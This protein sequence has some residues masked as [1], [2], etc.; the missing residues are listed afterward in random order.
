MHGR[1]SLVEQ[2]RQLSRDA[3]AVFIDAI[4]EAVQLDPNIGYVLVQLLS[5]RT[6]KRAS[7]RLACRPGLWTVDLAEGL[8]AALPGFQELE[9]LPL[10]LHG[11]EEMAG[12][13]ADAF[14]TAVADARLTRLL[15]QP[16]HARALLD[17]WRTTRELP[18][19]RSEAMRH[20][21]SN[22]L[23]E[24]G[25][26][27]PRRVHDDRRMAL[28]AERLAAVTIFCG[29]GRFGLGQVNNPS[30]GSA[31]SALLPVTAVPT[32]HEPDLAG[33]MTV[34]DLHEVLNTTLFSAAGQ[35][36]VRFAHQSY[37]E[38]LAAAYL[39][40]RGVSGRRLLSL[41][42]ADANGLA[43]GPM[44]EVLG[45]LLPLGASIPA[46]LIADNAK[47]LLSTTGLE[48][49]DDKM[50]RRVVDAL[51]RGA[52]NGSIDE[53]W[54]LDTSPLAHPD[55]G[56]QIHE[57]V[58]R[59]ANHWEIF[60]ICRITRHCR[61]SDAAD[62]LLAIAFNLTW[63]SFVRAEAVASFAAV[64][65]PVRVDELAPLL[66]LSSE[67]DPQ[68]EILAAALRALLTR[69]VDLDRL[70][71]ALRP[72]RSPSYIGSYSRLLDELPSLL[73]A[74]HVL[75]VLRYAVGRRPNH[76]DYAFDRLLGGLLARA[77]TM[78]EP[79]IA[80]EVG[81]L[82]G[83]ERLGGQVEFD[84]GEHPWEV[85]DNP[86]LR[87]AM[88]AAMLSVHHNAFMAVLDL[89]ILTPQD[90]TWLIDW[91]PSAPAQALAAAE[92]VLRQLAWNVAD[93]VTADRI[94]TV[95]E[96]HPAYSILSQ[97]QGYRDI[98]ARPDWGVRRRISDHQRPGPERH[99][100]VLRQTLS[101]VRAQRDQW[102]EAALA[103]AGDLHAAD[104][105][106][107]FGW[108]LT[109][110]PLWPLLDAEEQEEFWQI[111]IAY[112][113][114]R[115]PEP[116]SWASR[117]RWTYQEIMPDWA[118]VYLLATLAEH[119]PDLLRRVPQRV[120]DSWAE[121]IV[122]TPA[123]MNEEQKKRRLGA[124]APPR[125]RA[126]LSAAL[127][128]HVRTAPTVAFPHHP[129]ADFTDPLLLD[130]VAAIARDPR[131]PLARR[132]ASF[133]VLVEHAPSVALDNARAT[134][135][136]EPAPAGAIEALAKLAPEE[137]LTPWLA[138]GQLGP[139]EHLREIDPIQLSDSSLAALS[140]LLLDRLPFAGDPER[141]DDFARSTP[142]SEARRL[143]MNLLQTMARR[144]MASH[145]AS[146]RTERPAEDQEQINH[147]LQQARAH[148]ALSLWRPLT[149]DTMMA[150]VARG[151]ARVIRD[152]AGLITV[153]L[154]QLDQIQHYVRERAGFRSLWN[155]DPGANAASPKM[156]D[157][158]S[159]WLAQ[160]LELRLTPHV[161]IDREIQVRRTAASGVGTRIDITA[162]SGGI[163][164]GRVVFEAKHV[165]NR[166]LLT[167][168]DHQ[169]I[170]R[171]MQPADLTHGIYIV[172]WT[173][174]ALRPSSWKRNHPDPSL[175]ADE[176]R[177]QARRHGPDRCVEVFVLDI[178]PRP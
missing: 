62:D 107:A 136:E 119:R 20:T 145:L 40:R 126:A 89:R 97:F 137:L 48:L 1:E 80:A 135:A 23:L 88:A 175:L 116:G 168:I 51:L 3:A 18:A 101:R 122:V 177:T 143:R 66:F 64:A 144:G 84:R 99:L 87:R 9:L 95:S 158:I 71:A 117:D 69:T 96:D 63:P 77:W 22:L 131:Q 111:G 26:F 65:A 139:L 157:D 120:W 34:E 127:R 159:D 13:D 152:S 75:P 42:G 21:V 151:D 114:A 73:D 121:T 92:V 6:A 2:I 86:D 29:V 108:D 41:L 148:E 115:Q 79:S 129:L 45:W 103:L 153:L 50:R 90:L 31:D 132:D 109:E 138:A 134:R 118:A 105:K 164:L 17:Q 57:A 140:R 38:F 147:L 5:E 110:R 102:W 33:Q 128:D 123:F 141:A 35:G 146:L 53:G 28:L 19:G 72:R 106:A 162:T 83:Q 113:S 81:G 172:Y 85:D 67:E 56:D 46:D 47:Q 61:V 93:R 112:L 59:A 37:A 52:A 170:G 14:L 171:Y 169:L 82:L 167:A 98:G 16:Q 27:R 174:P 100:A 74:D 156:E 78:H 12:S 30:D 15:A 58:Q 155:G 54:N 4:D 39:A 150:L 8:R 11:I 142:E 25:R 60:W 32:D 76:R 166:D 154:E 104:P 36:S 55:I 94:L 178:G 70:T 91:I 161:I 49:A 176:L 133:E 24:T 160:Q 10:D 163:Q 165:Q 124:S 125:G 68:D 7:W 130:V 173:A 149:P 43:P 44:I